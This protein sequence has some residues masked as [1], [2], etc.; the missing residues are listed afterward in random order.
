VADEQSGYTWDIEF[1]FDDN[2]GNVES[3]VVNGDGLATTNSIGG[4]L[5][6]NAGGVDGSF[7][8]GTFWMESVIVSIQM[9]NI[10]FHCTT[11]G[12]STNPIPTTQIW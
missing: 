6:E 7:I 3:I 9:L 4:A 2:F 10:I 11:G 8:S 12:P 5:V 1:V